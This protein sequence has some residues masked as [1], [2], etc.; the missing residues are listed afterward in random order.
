MIYSR[1]LHF[2]IRD[3]RTMKDRDLHE[4]AS[5]VNASIENT[6]SD[7]RLVLFRAESVFNPLEYF[8]HSPLNVT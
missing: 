8:F 6:H 1:Y 2:I 5:F 3:K 4:E 7:I